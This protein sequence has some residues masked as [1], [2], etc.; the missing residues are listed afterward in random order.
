L[1]LGFQTE[2]GSDSFVKIL[3]IGR[4]LATIDLV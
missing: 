4:L 2:N 1:A 3:L